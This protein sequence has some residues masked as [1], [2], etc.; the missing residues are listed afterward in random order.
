MARI[1]RRY[2]LSLDEVAAMR[3]AQGGACKICK[4]TDK[5]LAIDHCH[6]TGR[7]RGLLCLSCNR[8]LGFFE[9]F[10]KASERAW[11]AAAIKYLEA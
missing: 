2:G 8:C 1:K 4:A 9:R 10:R 5:K 11:V 3:E 7:V 6:E